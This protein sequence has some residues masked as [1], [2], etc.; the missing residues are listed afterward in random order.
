M[1]T[2]TGILAFAGVLFLSIFAVAG[3]AHANPFYLLPTVQTA[4]ATSS[5]SFMNAGNATTTLTLDAYSSGGPKADDR[6]TLFVQNAASSTSSILNI[7]IQYSQDSIDWYSDN[8]SVA[9][10]SNPLQIQTAN[11]YTWTA[12]GTATSSKA[13]VVM[14]PVRYVRAVFTVPIGAAAGAVWAQFVPEEQSN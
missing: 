13:L 7:A 5:V 3:L 6:A 10:S 9:S 2:K 1:K 14:T 8:M 11:T 4:T 12:A